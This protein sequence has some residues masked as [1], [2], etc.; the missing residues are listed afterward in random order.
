LFE[1]RDSAIDAD[2]IVRPGTS[3]DLVE[4]NLRPLQTTGAEGTLALILTNDF[5]RSADEIGNPL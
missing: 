3:E 4:C 5:A 2:Q 1:I